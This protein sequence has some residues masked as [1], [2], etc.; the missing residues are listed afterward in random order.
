M[1][2]TQIVC[3]YKLFEYCLHRYKKREVIAD[4]FVE[5]ND[6][7]FMNRKGKVRIVVNKTQ[8]WVP[9]PMHGWPTIVRRRG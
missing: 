5:F 1:N 8:V 4:K 9:H 7:Y 2:H 3:S 6:F